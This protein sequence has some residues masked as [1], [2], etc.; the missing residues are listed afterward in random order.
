M[1]SA[2]K[3][4]FENCPE[5]DIQQYD[6]F[7]C[8]ADAIISPGNSFAKM[9]GGMD[10]LCVK[11]FGN[12]IQTRVAEAV[13]DKGDGELLVGQA[14]VVLTDY[15][16]LPYLIYAP[17]VR[18]AGDNAIGTY[19]AYLAFR[20]ALLVAKKNGFQ[21]IVCPGLCTFSG[22]MAPQESAYQMLEAYQNYGI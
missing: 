2:W 17:T 3:A 6:I 8:T 10:Y 12:R 1:V 9:T 20:A 7:R 11:H 21:S 16:S 22:Q 4:A 15:P 13:K 19:N 5:V 14:V 18:I